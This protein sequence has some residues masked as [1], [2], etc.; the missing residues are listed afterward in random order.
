MALSAGSLQSKIIDNMKAKGAD[1]DNKH[2]M[3]NQLA[4]SIAKA[5]IDEITTSGQV[6]TTAPAGTWKIQ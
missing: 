5:V 6:V 4:E 1:V 3:L 2:C